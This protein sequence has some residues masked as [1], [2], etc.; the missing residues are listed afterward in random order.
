M[1]FVVFIRFQDM[2]SFYNV[3]IGFNLLLI[4]V[5]LIVILI[6]NLKV[7]LLLLPL[8]ILISVT[9]AFGY[10]FFMVYFLVCFINILSYSA[11]EQNYIGISAK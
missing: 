3:Y 2:L 4:V 10:I 1:R 5:V 11:F 8:F 7:N 6:V 9:A